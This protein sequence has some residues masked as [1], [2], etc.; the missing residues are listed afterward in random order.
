[1]QMGLEMGE[2]MS[3]EVKVDSKAA[4]GIVGRRGNGKLRYVRVGTLWLQQLEEEEDGIAFSHVGGDQTPADLMTKNL[5]AGQA[6]ALAERLS[7]RRRGGR[8]AEQ[9]KV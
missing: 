1:M 8:A 9:L 2:E 5:P 7:Q 6:N 4:L 3:A